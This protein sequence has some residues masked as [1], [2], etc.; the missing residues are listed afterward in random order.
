MPHIKS[1]SEWDGP[2]PVLSQVKYKDD[3][4]LT[5]FRRG[6][7]RKKER[8]NIVQVVRVDNYCCIQ[9]KLNIENLSNGF[10]LNL[11]LRN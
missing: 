4:H 7:I 5:G 3:S 11:N 9:I 1:F 6:F 2:F 10:Q 8:E